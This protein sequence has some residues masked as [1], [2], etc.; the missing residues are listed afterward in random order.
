MGDP[1]AEMANFIFDSSIDMLAR[2][3]SFTGHKGPDVS[4]KI[5]SPTRIPEQ[6]ITS[7]TPLVAA[8]VQKALESYG[9]KSP[10]RSGAKVLRFSLL[11]RTWMADDLCSQ[12]ERGFYLDELEIER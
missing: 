3:K 8:P 4:I 9:A 6:T 5:M 7:M 1:N 12:E 2:K 11:N 10:R